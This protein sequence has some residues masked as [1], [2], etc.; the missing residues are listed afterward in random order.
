VDGPLGAATIAEELALSEG[1]D[2]ACFTGRP[3]AGVDAQAWT[4]A[5]R[6]VS[7]EF[8]TG[9]R[10]LLCAT[11]AFGLGVD[12]ADVRF[13]AHLGLPASL[14][15]YYQQA[16]RAG[17]D[18]KPAECWLI[19]QILSRRRARRW[20]SLRLERLREEASSLPARGR[21][22]VS[23]AYSLHLASFRGEEAERRDA[24][25]A[26]LAIGDPGQSGCVM[27][28]TL[29]QDPEAL[30][31]ALLRFE[32]AGA[33]TLDERRAG[34]WLIQKKGGWE[35][36]S[37]TRAVDERIAHDYEAVEPARR[38]SLAALV[39]LATS[40]DAGAALARELIGYNAAP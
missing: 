18:G 5:K 11:R 13:V 31:R 35:V 7:D 17:R 12:R 9:R 23:R 2:A 37:L 33:L 28:E 38:A 6:R 26:L 10:G 14:E 3:P 15:E 21:D 34:G 27:V 30:T 29:G 39:E 40:S 32:E 1:I 19:L 16:G 36:R 20:A 24:E 4:A 25:I 22:D 8:L